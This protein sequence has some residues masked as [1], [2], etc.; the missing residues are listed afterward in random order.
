MSYVTNPSKK[1]PQV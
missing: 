1:I